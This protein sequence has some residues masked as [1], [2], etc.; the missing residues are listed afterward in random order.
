[1]KFWTGIINVTTTIL[2]ETIMRNFEVKHLL[3]I[4]VSQFDA[5][6]C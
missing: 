3:A 4:P 6:M 2:Q 1:V 5:D